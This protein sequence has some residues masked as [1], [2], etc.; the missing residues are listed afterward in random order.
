M[1]IQTSDRMASRVVNIQSHHLNH[2]PH[3][4]DHD[5]CE[6]LRISNQLESIKLVCFG[7]YDEQ[8][9]RYNFHA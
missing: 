2:C 9:L 6:R 1:E 8:G 5:G 4:C 7:K 3:E